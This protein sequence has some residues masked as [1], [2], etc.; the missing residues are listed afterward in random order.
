MIAIG[1]AFGFLLGYVAHGVSPTENA[2]AETEIKI[3]YSKPIEEIKVDAYKDD[4]NEILRNYK[5]DNN[6]EVAYNKILKMLVPPGFLSMHLQI[7][8]AFRELSTGNLEEG[9]LKLQNLKNSHNWLNL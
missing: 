8:V 3:E 1:L 9:T 6:S 7:T 4:L 2:Y 5:N